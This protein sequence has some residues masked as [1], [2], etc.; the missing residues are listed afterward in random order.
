MEFSLVEA[1]KNYLT[2]EGRIRGHS[3]CHF[4]PSEASV[5][6]TDE[7]GKP[8]TYG[9]CLRATYFRCTGQPQAPHSAKTQRIFRL[10]KIVEE[11]LIEDW[12]CMGIFE[13]SNIRFQNPEYNLSG[14]LDAVLRDPEGRLLGVECKSYYGY[15][16]GKQIMGN[17][18]QQP[19]PKWNQLLQ[20]IVYTKEFLGKIEYFKMFY[21]ERG[22]GNEQEFDVRVVPSED[23]DSAIVHRVYVNDDLLNFTVEDIYERFLIL[24]EYIIE[25]VPPERDYELK[26]SNE[27]IEDL[28]SKKKISKS[29]Y[30]KFKKVKKANGA[31]TYNE[32]E[33][34]GDWMC[35]YCNFKDLC[36]K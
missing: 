13:A 19:F 1:T 18:S 11:M 29:A 21:E 26:Y 14:E 4:W 25:G 7:D 6:T 22:N 3:S 31:V 24:K 16:A 10:G 17:R 35:Q 28:Y 2:R 33:R 34:P 9:G 12:K 36:W 27:K 15:N 30:E 8:I 20:T 5:V 23:D 32:R